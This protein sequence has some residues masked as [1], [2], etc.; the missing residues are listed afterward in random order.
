M[1]SSPSILVFAGQKDYLFWMSGLKWSTT[2][3]RIHMTI[4]T[5]M[6]TTTLACGKS[7]QKKLLESGSG[8]SS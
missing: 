2:G 5:T 6:K 1:S 7:R 8:T 4:Q 3:S